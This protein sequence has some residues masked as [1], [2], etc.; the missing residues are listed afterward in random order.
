[1][2]ASN[3]HSAVQVNLA[4][5][6]RKLTKYRIHTE[7]SILIDEVEYKPDLCVYPYKE[8]DRKHDIIKMQDL[9][10]SAI[11]I[12]SPTQLPQAIVT[13][14][15]TYLEAG[16]QSCWMVLPYPTT[17]TVYNINSEK[18]FIEGNIVDEIIGIELPIENIFF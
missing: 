5:E 3:I 6:L 13:K 1:M 18:S 9:P 14:I 2:A 11:E 17:I 15:E 8:L 7:L 16:I 10:L 12:V 4:H